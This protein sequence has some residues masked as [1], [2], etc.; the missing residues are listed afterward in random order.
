MQTLPS[1][2]SMPPAKPPRAK[3]WSRALLLASMILAVLTV[4][5]LAFWDESR[6]STAAFE[7]F[8]AE[9]A[10][11]AKSLAGG[12]RARLETTT[13][14]PTA[15][16]LVTI[17]RDARAIERPGELILLVVPPSSTTFVTTD[18]RAVHAEGI[19]AAFAE[20]SASLRLTREEAAS[21]GLP[22]RAAVAGIAS[23]AV[24]DTTTPKAPG[25]WAI[26][27]VATARNVRDR[28]LR[29]RLRLLLGVGLAAGL[30]GIFG[31]LALRNQR[32]E[33]QLERELA[34][35][36][37]QRRRDERLV[38]A[39]RVAMMGTLATGV[40]HE[41]G[42]PLGVIAGRAEQLASRAGNDERLS[43]I[44]R[45]IIEQTDRIHQVVRGF[46][47]LS[48]GA[49]PTLEKADPAAIVRAAVRLTEHR[50]EKA[51]VTLAVDVASDLPHVHCDPRL[52]EH[53]VV[54]LLL[55]AC[56]A[57]DGGLVAVRARAGSA[58]VGISVHDDGPG[59]SAEAAAHAFEPF[60]TTKPVGQG[61]GLGLAITNEIVKAHHGSLA[62]EPAQG[63]GTLARIELP[64]AEGESRPSGASELREVRRDSA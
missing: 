10:T 25:R 4:A 11:L 61:T 64:L 56:E 53:A 59:I 31:T 34:M 52:M 30:V 32:K 35:V 39:Q 21:L 27:S 7:D 63:G 58:A 47:D 1:S 8:S 48:R 43:R 51:N 49:S 40:A 38:R 28:E 3:R 29:A 20:G 2:P 16:E 15:A 44:A 12:L 57:S 5:S 41:I 50:F 9:Q 42:T 24:L 55:N 14:E 22:P 45:V 18:G 54:N 6:E 60:F 33:L 62:I 37:L 13:G 36:D 17:L 23:V 46:L 26:V 19:L